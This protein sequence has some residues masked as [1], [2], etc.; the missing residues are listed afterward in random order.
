MIYLASPYSDND[1]EVRERRFEAVCRA[2]AKLIHSGKSVYA[3]IAHTHPICRYG[4]PGD[5]QFWQHHDRK[6][7]EIC[8]E[9]VVLM[10][11]GWDKSEGVQAEISIARE[12]GKPVTFIRVDTQNEENPGQSRG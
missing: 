9:V 2:A 12:M 1:A 3:P 7:I 6:Y 8:D 10:L 5:W 4:L 11:D